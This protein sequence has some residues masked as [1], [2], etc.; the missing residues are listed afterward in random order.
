MSQ[1]RFGIS[2]KHGGAILELQPMIKGV[3]DEPPRAILYSRMS[4]A[5]Q[6][7]GD[8]HRRQF[9]EGH[10]CAKQRGL[11]LKPEDL[12]ED[13]GLSAYT[14]ENVEKGKLGEILSKI[15]SGEI[16]FGSIL[17]VESIDRISRQ[18]PFDG[19]QLLIEILGKGI[20]VITFGDGKIY[21]RE[22]QDPSNFFSL[23]ISN[24]RS[25]EES[26]NKSRHLS[27]SWVNKRARAKYQNLTSLA[28]GWLK[29]NE[30]RHGFDIIPER[31]T[32]V[33][34][35]IE[36]AL[37]GMGT[38]AIVTRLNRQKVPTFG[39]STGWSKSSVNK[40]LKSHA[41]FGEY[42]P[43]TK[44]RGGKRTPVGDPITEILS[45]YC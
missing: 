15:E 34:T 36:W 37:S 39:R 45:S 27:Q 43:H 42:Q 11:V 7:K 13:I 40:I 25:N 38:H 23:M 8:S 4:T 14:G 24:L 35:I 16:P 22:N 21:D 9:E 18:H 41:I 31:E 2:N 12:F 20:K 19:L 17:L 1:P 44:P 30:K 5:D 26:K 6:L 32:V 10:K 3:S 28:P 33:R 29:A